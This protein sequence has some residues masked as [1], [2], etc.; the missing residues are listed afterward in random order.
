MLLSL[1]ANASSFSSANADD[2]T[3]KT[4]LSDVGKSKKKQTIHKLLSTKIGKWVIK[5]VIKKL[6]KNQIKNDIKTN[7]NTKN[8]RG[9]AIL[10]FGALLLIG[11]IVLLFTDYIL[12][13]IILAVLGLAIILLFLYIILLIGNAFSQ[14]KGS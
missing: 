6:Q 3:P 5:K 12:L 2:F 10:S 7:K 14:Y 13:G 11:G 9:I 4:E 8:R 1:N